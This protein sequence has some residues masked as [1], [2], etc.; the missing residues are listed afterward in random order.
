MPYKNSVISFRQAGVGKQLLFCFHGFAEDGY[1]FGMF[2][3]LLGNQ[4]TLIAMDF[5]FHGET[6]WK[7]GLLVTPDDLIEIISIISDH[8][9]QEDIQTDKYSMLAYSL[10]GRVAFHLLQLTPGKIDRMVL[11]APDGLTMNFWYW[12]G[13][14]TWLGNRFFKF[15]MQN[16]GWFFFLVKMGHKTGLVNKSIFKFV[17]HYIDDEK[18][19]RNLYHR[20]TTM[21]RFKPHFKQIVELLNNYPVKLSLFFGVYDRVISKERSD[22][23]KAACPKINIKT[24]QAGHQLLREKHALE[25]AAAFSE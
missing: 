19:R 7:E 20:W 4:F 9:V 3:K 24:L 14:Q 10:G 13:T 12:L 6:E 2:E 23:L 25:I 18:A 5:P 8:F 1:S 15:T 17:Y 16:P 22:F 21:R 11:V